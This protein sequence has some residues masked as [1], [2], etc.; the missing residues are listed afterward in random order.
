MTRA[1][2]IPLLLLVV[3]GLV[4]VCAAQRGWN[5]RRPARDRDGTIID[6]RGVDSW[7]MKPGFK[8]DTFTFVRIAYRSWNEWGGRGRG[9]SASEGAGAGD[10]GGVRA[11]VGAGGHGDLTGARVARGSRM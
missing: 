7:E 2:T 11:L 5:R 8:D 9:R 4:S 1:K 6:R 10:R 3:V